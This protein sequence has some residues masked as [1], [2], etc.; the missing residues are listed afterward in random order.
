MINVRSRHPQ[1]FTL[2]E[3]M[4][5]I[6]II[7]ILASMLLPALGRARDV[8]KAN[9]CLNNLHQCMLAVVGYGDDFNGYWMLHDYD[10]S[11]SRTWGSMT[12]EYN[13]VASSSVLLCPAYP[14]YAFSEYKSYGASQNGSTCVNDPG[15]AQ[16]IYQRLENRPAPSSFCLL[17]DSCNVPGKYQFSGFY[18][19]DPVN[20]VHAR[21][22]DKVQMAFLDGHVKAVAVNDIRELMKAQGISTILY[23]AY[24]DGIMM[25]F[26]P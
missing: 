11:Q 17:A 23:V 4:V 3:L 15:A 25:A 10:G 16:A 2:I 26:P 14:P 8:A 6:A 13:Y 18:Y 19:N 5:V 22:A 1:S 9:Q 12:L 24:A 20:L 7:A 21:H